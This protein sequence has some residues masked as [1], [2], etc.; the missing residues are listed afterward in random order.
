MRKM[1]K[2]INTLSLATY[3]CRCFSFQY[4]MCKTS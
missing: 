4:L 1:E 2:D 3:H